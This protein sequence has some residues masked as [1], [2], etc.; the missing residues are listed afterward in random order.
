MKCALI[1]TVKK[2]LFVKSA[3]QDSL[4]LARLRVFFELRYV[5]E[6]LLKHLM[7]RRFLREGG[8]EFQTDDLENARLVLYRSMRGRGRIKLLEPFLLMDIVK[9]ERM[10]SGVYPL[11]SL[12][13]ITTLLYFSCFV[14]GRS[15]RVF[16]SSSVGIGRSE[17]M[18]F[19]VR[20]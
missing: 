11:H 6:C 1:H 12:D 10:F 18:S 3:G 19:A 14:N 15:L 5:C 2:R 20:Q 9:S 8:R 7:V 13:I 4:Q 17:R 16:S